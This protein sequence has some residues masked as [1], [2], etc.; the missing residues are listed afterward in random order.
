MQILPQVQA[1]K[2]RKMCSDFS[3]KKALIVFILGLKFAFKM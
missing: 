3:G 2:N 1:R